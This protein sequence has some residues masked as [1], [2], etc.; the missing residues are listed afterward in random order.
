MLWRELNFVTGAPMRQYRDFIFFERAEPPRYMRE[1]AFDFA[2]SEDKDSISEAK[3]EQLRDAYLA[4]APKNGVQDEALKAIETYFAEISAEIRQVEQ[5]RLA[6]EPSHLEALAEVRR[7]RLSPAALSQPS[8][9]DLIAFYRSLR[10][11]DGLSHE[12]AIRDTV[13][14]VLLSPHFAI[15]STRPSRASAARPLSSY[16]LASRLSYFLWSSM[17]DDEL[18]VSRRRRRSWSDRRSCSRKPDACFETRG[19]A[20]LPRSSPGTGWVSAA[21]RSTTPSI[22]SDFPASRTS[23]ARRCTK[24]RFASSI[25]VVSRDRSVLDLLYGNDTFVNPV[26]A[27]H[28]GMPVPEGG[29]DDWVRVDDADRFGRGGLLPMSVFLTASSPGLRTSPVKRGYWVVRKLLGERIPPPPAVV[30]ELPKDE[31]DYRRAEPAAASGPAPRRQELRELPPAV[32]LDRA[33]LRGLR[34][35][36]RTARSRPGR[37]P[38]RTPRPHFPTA[39]KATASPA[40]A[41]TSPSAARTSSSRTSAA[42]CSSTPWDEA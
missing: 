7:A 38:G 22:A 19:F 10:E 42:S 34:P 13:A 41:D 12:D 28:Y 24:S 1:S 35:D 37:P 27:K 5:D 18:L 32:R 20:G 11:K 30:P 26:L 29:K 3:I 6:A 2:R 17:P 16:E 9:D 23:C 8:D 33:G 15:A 31:A 25:D 39:A 21:S 4:K 40:C 36:R 14:S